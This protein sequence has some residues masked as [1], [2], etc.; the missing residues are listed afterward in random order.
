[1]VMTYVNYPLYIYPHSKVLTIVVIC[2]QP[3]THFLRAKTYPKRQA[4]FLRSS[5]LVNVVSPK[6]YSSRCVPRQVTAIA[7]TAINGML[8]LPFRIG[9][10]QKILIM[11]TSLQ[12]QP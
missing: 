12:Q 5:I 9:Q 7:A 6:S 8:W 11:K 1:M 4:Y 3:T 2:S 10:T